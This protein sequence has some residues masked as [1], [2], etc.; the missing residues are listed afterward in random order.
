MKNN[1]GFTLIEL[2]ITVAVIAILASIALPNYR[3]YV[4]RTNR[5][6]AIEAISAAAVCLE[7][8]YS[9]NSTYIYDGTCRTTP[10]GY[11]Q[12][13]INDIANNGQEF[14]IVAIP[15]GGQVNDS[16]NRL[17]L[18]HTGRKTRTGSGKSHADCWA[19]R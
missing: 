14:R 13:V 15:N 7:R 9:R 11:N 8:N 12:L 3:E 18:D 17:R 16:C 19:G 2:M 1:Q 6:A 4:I 5:T 10:Q